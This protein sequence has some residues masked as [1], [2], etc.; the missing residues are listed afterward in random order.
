MLDKQSP[1]PI[2]V[3]I[4]E[5]LKSQISDGRFPPGAAIPSERELTE[6]FGVSRMTVRQA[7]TNLVNEGLLFREKG[8]GTFVAVPKVEQPLSGMT[9]FTEDMLARGMKP[10][11]QLLTFGKRKPDKQVAEELQLEADEEVFFVERIRY[12][13]SIPMAIE[14][15]YLPVKLFP[16]LNEDVLAGSLYVFVEGTARL[17]I[18]GAVQKMEAALVKREDAELLHVETPFSVLIIER[19]SKLSNGVPFEVVRSTYR[20]DRYKFTSEIQR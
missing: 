3:Q 14:R 6:A 10:S 15:T 5:R 11:N 2:Y 13:D 1:I 4:E 9:S 16:E 20:A 8:R 19:I 17:K 18:G 12:A 7:I